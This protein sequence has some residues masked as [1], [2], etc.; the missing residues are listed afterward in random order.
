MRFADCEMINKYQYYFLKPLHFGLHNFKL[1]KNPLHFPVNPSVLRNFF[2][3]TDATRT[4]NP[5]KYH[6]KTFN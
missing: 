1:I 2:S 6:Q 5:I 3:P 4:E